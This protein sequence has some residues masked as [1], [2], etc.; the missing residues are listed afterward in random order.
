MIKIAKENHFSLLKNSKK[1]KVPSS[2]F[3]ALDTAVYNVL[4]D[5]IVQIRSNVL[6]L[7]NIL[8]TV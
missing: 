3:F 2:E 8:F 6:Q 7:A 1:P 5:T 4:G